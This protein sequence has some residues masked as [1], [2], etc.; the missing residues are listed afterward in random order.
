[1][2]T[3]DL[4]GHDM[5]HNLKLCAK[6]FNDIIFYCKFHSYHLVCMNV[7]TFK[8]KVRFH[9]HAMCKM[10]QII[11]FGYTILNYI[12]VVNS[13]MPNIKIRS[14]NGKCDLMFGWWKHV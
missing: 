5:K 12:G 7:L 2:T 3:L 1:M 9:A 10:R 13:D 4:V 6:H 11:G 14:C 8:S